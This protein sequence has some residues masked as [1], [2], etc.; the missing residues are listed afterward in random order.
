VKIRGFRIE[1][2][3]I[4]AQLI[5]HAQVREAVV[6]AR[7]DVPGDRR[8]VAYVVPC[9][10]SAAA[11]PSAESLR[12]QLRA[13]LPDYMVPSA[14]VIL[15]ALPQTPNGKLNRRA[16]PIPEVT[17]YVTQEYEAPQ[18]DTEKALARIWLELVPVARVGRHANFLDLGGHSL[19][20]TR[21]ISRISE[22]LHVELSVGTIFNAA[23]LQQ[24]ADHVESARATLASAQDL[25]TEALAQR[26]RKDIN[27]MSDDMVLARIADFEERLGGAL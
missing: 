23:T 10:S 18:G 1:L 20:A 25:S 15:E 19:L 17:A 4:E 9:D 12:A 22:V 26:L 24:L 11:A 6:I 7:E 5:R 2:G 27:D 14:F 13:A 8:L 3:E 16:L 21:M